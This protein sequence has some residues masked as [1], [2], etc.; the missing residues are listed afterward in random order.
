MKKTIKTSLPIFTGYQ[1]TIFGSIIE[2]IENDG[3]DDI[4]EEEFE[5]RFMKIPYNEIRRDLAVLACE[6]VEQSLSEFVSSVVYD[7]I[8]S[9]KFYNHSNDLIDCTIEYDSDAIRDFIYKHDDDFDEFLKKNFT[10]YSGFMSFYSN[11]FDV[12]ETSSEGFTE[13]DHK[14]IHFKSILNFIAWKVMDD[15][16]LDMYYYMNEN[17]DYY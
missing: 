4:S 2:D 16:K 11:K 13:F 9:P 7:G 14:D 15:P 3:R 8:D 6:F 10:S 17:K 5:E 12:W 1:Y